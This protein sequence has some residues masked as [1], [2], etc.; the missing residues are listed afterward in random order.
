MTRLVAAACALLVAGGVTH[1]T[2]GKKRPPEDP[3]KE[4]TPPPAV[5]TP[6]PPPDEPPPAP[7][8]PRRIVAVL[9]VRVDG[10]PAE[11]AAQ[12]QKSLEAQVD[13]KQFWLAGRARVHES[14]ANSTKWTEGCVVGQCLAEVKVQTHADLVLLAALTGAG[15][16]FGFVVTLVRT[17]TGR[18]VAQESK[19]CDVCTIDQ[20]MSEA[21]LAT[22]EIL[23]HVPDKLPDDAVDQRRAISAATEPF[24]RE[25]QGAR[26]HDHALGAA[27]TVTGLVAVAAGV[28]AYYL[29]SHAS[30]GLVTAAAGGGLVAGGVVVLT[31]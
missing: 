9:D 5:P 19:R 21:T 17:D 10:V 30:Y 7:G 12:F 1:A 22:V 28:A 13:S 26:H 20:A 15:T 8:D 24:A 11:I 31:F 6:P 4:A 3:K 16:S 25:V 29:K 2:P 27:L 23:M 18:V 14:M